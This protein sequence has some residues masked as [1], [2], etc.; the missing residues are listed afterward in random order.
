M[1]CFFFFYVRSLRKNYFLFWEDKQP[2]KKVFVSL[3]FVNGNRLCEMVFWHAKIADFAFFLF[4]NGK[5]QKLF[6][7]RFLTNEI[8]FGTERFCFFVEKSFL[9]IRRSFRKSSKMFKN[10]VFL[11]VKWSKK[12]NRK[13]CGVKVLKVY[14]KLS[15]VQQFLNNEV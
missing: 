4:R 2:L 8:T 3:E 7:W 1:V 9:W 11:S 12:K 14:D 15:L 5:T 6:F 10:P 13:T